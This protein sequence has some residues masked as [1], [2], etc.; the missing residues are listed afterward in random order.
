MLAFNSVA[1]LEWTLG[2]PAHG[3]VVVSLNFRLAHEELVF[4][5]RDAGLEVMLTDV[6][7]APAAQ[8]LAEDVP[9]LRE[10]LVD[11]TGY[12]ARLTGSPAVARPREPEGL[13]MISYTGGTTGRPKGVMLSH[14]NLRANA[15]HNAAA[16]GHAPDQVWLH[17][18][19]MFHVAGT[20]NVLA[21]TKAGARQVV[22]PRFDAGRVLDAVER[23]R[24]THAIFVPTMLGMLLDDPAFDPARLAS[25]RHLQYA[26][27]PIDPGVQRRVLDAL[28]HVEVEQFYGM[29]E[30]APSVSR[31]PAD[32]HRRGRAGVAPWDAR[33]RSVGRALPGIDVEVRRADGGLALPEEIGELTVRGP[34]VML[35]Y[36]NRPD[37]TAAALVDGWY[38]TGDLGYADADGYVFLVD[39]LKDMIVSGGENVYSVEVEQALVRHA[40]VA[41]A[42]VFG[43]PHPRWGEAVRAVVVLQRS[44]GASEDEL[45]EHCRRLLAGFKVPRELE[46]TETPLPRS[47]AGKVLKHV[48]REPFWNGRDRRVS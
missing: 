44:D 1:H 18:C 9:T 40:A 42:A 35:G 47:G 23:E 3:R 22:L 36:L 11:G 5:A 20:A 8:R 34:N 6:A 14:A 15:A 38:R 31:L 2:V 13:A 19:P 10:V 28:P 27:S 48:L 29:T 24:V 7:H 33:L 41:E 17:V 16:V 21:A 43:V 45:V 32:A 25:L 26:A 37:E 39:R 30:A 12:D 46:L 4:I